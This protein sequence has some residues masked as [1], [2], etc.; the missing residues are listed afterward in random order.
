MPRLQEMDADVTRGEI[1]RKLNGRTGLA[2]LCQQL[3]QVEMTKSK[4][5][6]NS[7]WDARQLSSGQ[8]RYAAYD[9]IFSR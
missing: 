7:L 9:A 6:Q 1:A 4:R 5:V 8:I 3:L 2:S